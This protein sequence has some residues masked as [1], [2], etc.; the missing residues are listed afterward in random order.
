[1][2]GWPVSRAVDDFTLV[3]AMAPA[4]YGR[5]NTHG[6]A[7]RQT[8]PPHRRSFADSGLLVTQSP[9]PVPATL[10][11]T[12]TCRS[13]AENR[14]AALGESVS[15]VD[16]D[17]VSYY[18]PLKLVQVKMTGRKKRPQ[19]ST[20]WALPDTELVP[21]HLVGAETRIRHTRTHNEHQTNQSRSKAL[22][23]FP[24]SDERFAVLAPRRNDSESGN[25]DLKS[26]MWKS[27][28]RTLRHESVEFNAIAYQ[29][30]T[31]VTSLVAYHNR[32]GADMSRWFG[33][34]QLPRK[35]RPQPAL[36]QAA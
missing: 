22:R 28:C 18:Q 31:A 27:R 3:A 24:E 32:T 9:Q 14:S 25:A 15:L 1:M 26:R 23:I 11:P 4:M 29:I 13:W 35:Q 10:N 6:T 5:I 34:H 17:G 8:V 19:T 36:A 20:R 12:L 7:L 33:N 21:A 2:C 30:H 16:G